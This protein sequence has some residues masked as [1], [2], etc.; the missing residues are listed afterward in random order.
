[1]SASTEQFVLDSMPSVWR[2]IAPWMD[3]FVDDA[4]RHF[5]TE[6]FTKDP[7]RSTGGAVEVAV[8]NELA[9]SIAELAWSLG[10]HPKAVVFSHPAYPQLELDAIR[11]VCIRSGHDEAE[12][13]GA[14][15]DE[16]LKLAM[17]LTW[18][19]T[20]RMLTSAEER[21]NLAFRPSFPGCGLL[22]PL[23][24]D[25]VAAGL[26]VEVKSGRRSVQSRDC[27]QLLLY[28]ALACEAGVD[29][30]SLGWVN[31]RRGALFRLPIEEISH[32]V[33]GRSWFDVR[34]GLVS[35][36]GLSISR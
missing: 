4:W 36:L 5:V 21:A 29:I 3:S 8:I 14:G 11:R 26:L 27:R 6:T 32:R 24:A 2:D 28:A 13:S 9:F 25:I 20:N 16:A 35:A 7:I 19:L 31:P 23:E 17:R 22:G 12:L 18:M 34:S 15:E 30:H 33:S 1:M 10:E